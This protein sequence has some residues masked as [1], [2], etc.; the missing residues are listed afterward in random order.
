MTR[1]APG[2]FVEVG[3]HRLHLH[4]AG[5][6][7][8]PV[9]FDSALGASSLSWSLVH[10]A[11]ARLTT[12]CVYDRAGF[13]WSDG[14]PMPRTA[15]RIADELHMLLARTGLRGPYVL[16]GHSFGGLVM[17]MYAARHRQDVAGLVLIEPAIPEEW[18]T[19]S[20]EQRA[21]L[22]RGERLCRYG[23]T[24]ARTGIA[25]LFRGFIRLSKAVQGRLG[26]VPG[27]AYVGGQGYADRDY[28]TSPH[29]QGVRV[30]PR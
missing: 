20:D 8:P 1:D 6:G 13:G 15:G 21:L 23:E 18:M 24:A 27:H 28:R 9:V 17:R 5:K 7:A 25:T 26:I 16:V 12:A 30:H 14:G 4:C 22:L 19:P 29:R 11:V 3:T 2:R 10:A